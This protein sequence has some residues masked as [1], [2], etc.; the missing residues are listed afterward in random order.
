M[1]ILIVSNSYPTT[2]NPT[3]QVFIRSIENGLRRA[4]HQTKMVYNRYFDLFESPLEAGSAVLGLI[5]ALFLILSSLRALL[6]SCRKADIIYSHAPLLPGLLMMAGARLHGIPHVTYAHGSVIQYAQ[7]R[8]L[9]YKLAAYTMRNCNLVFT[10][11]QYM[12]KQLLKLYGIQSEVVTPGYNHRV[13]HY[14]NVE[15]TTDILFAGN[16]IHRKGVHIL[17]HAIRNHEDWYRTNNI[18]IQI[19]CSG[20]LKPDMEHF[21]MNNQLQDLLNIGDKLEERD[22]ALAYCRSKLVVYPSLDEPLGLVGIEAIACGAFLIASNVGGIPEYVKD[23]ETGLLFEPGNS[24][25]LQRAIELAMD[26]KLWNRP[27]ELLQRRQQ[28][29]KPFTIEHGT[30]QAIY[31]FRNMIKTDR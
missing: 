5:K 27:E 3:R 31:H 17:L 28:A 9:I 22:L 16:C 12:Q 24:N 19:H 1:R 29:L 4:G 20:K 18:R 30:Q 8:G 21:C 11:S 2:K 7:K 15:K 6:F 25:A 10:N 26:E 13:F 14:R 23:E